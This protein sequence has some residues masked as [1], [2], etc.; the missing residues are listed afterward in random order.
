MPS[1]MCKSQGCKKSWQLGIRSKQLQGAA[2]NITRLCDLARNRV[3]HASRPN[4]RDGYSQRA[5]F[6][7]PQDFPQAVTPVFDGHADVILLGWFH[8]A[9]LETSRVFEESETHFS[10][11]AIALLGNDELGATLKLGIVRFVHFLAEN[12]GNHV[13]VLLDRAGLPQ[14]GELRAMVSTA[15]F[16]RAAELGKSNYGNT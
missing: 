12:E 13:C 7:V 11:R 5:C 4:G 8:A 9:R 3:V 16:R 6:L 14:V 1:C 15:A 10:S 2:S